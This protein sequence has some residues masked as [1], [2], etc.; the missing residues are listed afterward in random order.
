MK[1]NPKYI[2]LAVLIS[3]AIVVSLY[4]I[5]DIVGESTAIGR[6]CLLF[7]GHLPHSLLHQY[8][9]WI[10]FLWGMFE[11]RV[12]LVEIRRQKKS[13]GLHLLPEEEHWVMA[14][15]DVSELKIKMIDLEKTNDYYLIQVIKKAC[16]K[17]RAEKSVSDVMNLVSSQVKINLANAESGQ[18][19]IRYLAWSMP[20]L[21]FIGTIFGIGASLSLADRA[22]DPEIL[23]QITN[24][25]YVAFDNTL[26]ALAFSIIL[27]YYY[28][29]LQA[30]E[31]HLHHQ[32]EQYVLD[33]L[34]N[35]LHLE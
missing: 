2:A 13:F 4:F 9:I 19:V 21:G 15:D 22:A 31:D 5:M 26:L 35:R 24:N 18:T 34:V 14:P 1:Q 16:T 11:I 28:N 10:A 20:A 32:I 7:G 27:L 23:R 8:L 25:M 29:T 12:R 17:F 6:V 33:N 30:E 3:T